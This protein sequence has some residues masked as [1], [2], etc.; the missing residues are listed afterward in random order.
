MPT[1]DFTALNQAISTLTDQVSATETTEAGAVALIKGFS[2]SLQKAVAD[3]LAA[4]DAADA[5]SI[6]AAND[7]IAAVTA[8]FQASAAALGAAVA[9]VPPPA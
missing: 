9:E 7:A 2:A 6:Q 4:D 1:N 5:G 3:A 8:R